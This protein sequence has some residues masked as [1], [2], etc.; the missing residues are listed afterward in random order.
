MLA[1]ELPAQGTVLEVAAGAGDHAVH[2]ARAFPALIWQPSDPDEAALASIEA[3]RAESGLANLRAPLLLNAAAR[4][5]PMSAADA[6]YCCNM[7]HISPIEATLGLLAGAQRLLIAAG[8]P[9]ILY[10]PYL[11][12]DVVTARSNADFD[13]S[14]RARNPAWGIRRREWLDELAATHGF[15]P[16]R[17]EPMPANNLMLVYRRIG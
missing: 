9:L 17:R 14:L 11:E 15:A 13:Q 12:D 8:A 4:D 7:V 6:V 2:F 5:W 1:E 3:W 16:H 10:G